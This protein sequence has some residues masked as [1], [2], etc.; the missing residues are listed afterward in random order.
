MGGRDL[1]AR[2]KHGK[3]FP[4]EVG[5]NPIDTPEGIVVLCSVV[6]LTDR[7]KFEEKIIQQSELLEQANQLSAIIQF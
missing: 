7:K 6:D 3:I 2:K 1:A 4:V 5:L